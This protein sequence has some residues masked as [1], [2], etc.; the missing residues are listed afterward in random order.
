MALP[1]PTIL[2]HAELLTMICMDLLVS[3]YNSKVSL[4]SVYTHFSYSANIN[5][6]IISSVSISIFFSTSAM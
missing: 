6:L 3:I 1:D 5:E 4:I 2:F